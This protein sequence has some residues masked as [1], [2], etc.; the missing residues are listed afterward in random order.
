MFQLIDTYIRLDYLAYIVDNLFGSIYNYSASDDIN[1]KRNLQGAIIRFGQI[2]GSIPKNTPTSST[3][4]FV[5]QINGP[6]TIQIYF[7]ENCCK[8]R[9]WYNADNIAGA[10]T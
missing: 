4:G 5:I 1:D 3:Y 9:M 7:S 8:H 2:S 6:R 10:W